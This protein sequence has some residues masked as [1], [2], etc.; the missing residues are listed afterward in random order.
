MCKSED[1]VCKSEDMVC[2]SENM[3][4]KLPG[5]SALG[6]MVSKVSKAVAFFLPLG[7]GPP[8]ISFLIRQ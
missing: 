4:C 3:V 8:L 6:E 1:M 5:P 7:P 2:K